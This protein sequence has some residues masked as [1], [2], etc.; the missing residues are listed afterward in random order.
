MRN[1]Y[2]LIYKAFKIVEQ[3]FTE[4]FE[5]RV[6]LPSGIDKKIKRSIIDRIDLSKLYL[7]A[8]SRT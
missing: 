7:Q 2:L 1:D 5:V 3:F 6:Q 4:N 8:I